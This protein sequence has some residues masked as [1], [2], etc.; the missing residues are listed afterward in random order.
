MLERRRLYFGGANKL[1]GSGRGVV[2]A[3]DEGVGSGVGVAVGV[4]VGV[5]VGV[6]V[7]VGVGG[8]VC[9]GV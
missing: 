7:G 6:G 5:D 1:V 9:E 2:V 4:S 3:V 8:D